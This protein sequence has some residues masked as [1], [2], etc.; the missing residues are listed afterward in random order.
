V[1]ATSGAILYRANLTKDVSNADVYRNHPGAA[2]TDTVDLETLG[3][4]AASANLSGDFSHAYSDINDDDIAQGTEGDPAQLG[5]RLDLPVHVVPGERR[6]HRHAAVCVGSR[7]ADVVADEPRAERR[8]G[9]LPGVALPR[10]P[11]R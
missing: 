1:D 4:P 8:P 3:L 7:R 10:S 9:V 5:Q 6:L 2:P 11:G